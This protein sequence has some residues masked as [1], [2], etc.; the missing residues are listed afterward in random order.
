MSCR[1]SPQMQ[2]IVIDRAL[3]PCSTC[4]LLHGT[5]CL[6]RL[7]TVFALP[8]ASR[9]GLASRTCDSTERVRCPGNEAF[10]SCALQNSSAAQASRKGKKRL[11][12]SFAAWVRNRAFCIFLNNVYFNQACHSPKSTTDVTAY[13]PTGHTDKLTLS[14]AA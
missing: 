13:N 5:K 14:T 4:S 8:K 11:K 9:T 3:S 12:L 10:D 7:A 6:A 2:V 1:S